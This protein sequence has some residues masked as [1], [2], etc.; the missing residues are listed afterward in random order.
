MNKVILMGRLTR[1]PNVRYSPRN[2]SQEEMAIARYTLAVD[3]RGAKDG[4]QS[5]DFISCVAFGRDGEFAEKYLK[6]GTKVV[7]TGRIQTGSYTNRDGQKVYTTD[8]IVEEQEFAESKKAAGQQDGN[9]GGNRRRTPFQLGAEEDGDMG[10]VEKVKNVIS[11]LRAEGK[12]EKEVSE[13]I[14]QAAEAATV[15]KKT[16]SPEHPEKIKA[17]GGENLQDALLKVGI[18]AKEALTAFESIYRPRRQEKSNNWRKYHGL[19]LKRSKGGKR[20]GDRKRNDSNSEN[21][22]IS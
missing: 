5:A 6:Q 1:D 19:P 9:N 12:T 3:R 11:K 8:V 15:L 17:A 18:S 2:N 16:E 20:R 22:G 13:I 10:F 4:Q 14:E 7:V 21:T